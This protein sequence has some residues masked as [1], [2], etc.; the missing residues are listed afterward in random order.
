MA[1]IERSA[2]VSYTPEQMFELVNDIESYPQFVPGCVGAS[3]QQDNGG[4]KVAT[5]DIA[6]AGIK[7]S[8]TTRNTLMR[9][10]RI[11]MTLVDGPFKS[12][13]GG[14]QFVALGDEGCK[15]VFKLEFEFASKLLGMAFGKIFNEITAKMVEAFVKRAN[16]VY[17]AE[18]V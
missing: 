9:P 5:L 16:Q 17:G 13:G 3:V 10:E 7:K 8:F 18:N 15:I 1:S 2:L 4:S 6:K 11:D 14:W 12:L